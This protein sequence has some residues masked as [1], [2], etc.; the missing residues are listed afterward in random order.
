MS[1]AIASLTVF[2]LALVV[3]AFNGYN[4]WR[5]MKGRPLMFMREDGAWVWERKDR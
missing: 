5:L 1:A 3:T 4:M 2:L